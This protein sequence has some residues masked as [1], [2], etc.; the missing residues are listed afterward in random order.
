MACIQQDVLCYK[1]KHLSYV[2]YKHKGFYCFNDLI[3]D[4]S[5]FFFCC[6]EA[7]EIMDAC[8]NIWANDAPRQILSIACG[9]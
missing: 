4:I 2:F 9:T 7:Q 3:D 5:I 1:S 6:S 8:R